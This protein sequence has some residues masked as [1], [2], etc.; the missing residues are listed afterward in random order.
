MGGSWRDIAAPII[1]DVITKTGREDL[2][3][4]KRALFDAYPFGERRYLPYKVWCDEIRRQLSGRGASINDKR[5]M[6]LF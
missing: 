3:A 5:T 2:Q 4:L 1:T 6:D